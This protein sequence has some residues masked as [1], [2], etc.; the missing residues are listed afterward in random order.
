[1]K[2]IVYIVGIT[3]CT[4]LLFSSCEKEAEIDVDD[5]S[6][7]I[8]GIWESSKIEGIKNGKTVRSIESFTD[9]LGFG[10]DGVLSTVDIDLSDSNWKENEKNHMRQCHIPYKEEQYT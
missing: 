1:M 4:G 6:N 5:Y 8:I 10:E 9:I 3:I 2:R 7:S